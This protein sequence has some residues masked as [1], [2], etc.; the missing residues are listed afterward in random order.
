[1]SF[2]KFTKKLNCYALNVHTA[3]VALNYLTPPLLPNAKLLMYTLHFYAT[4]YSVTEAYRT[5]DSLVFSSLQNR[6]FSCLQLFTE[7]GL[8]EL[9]YL[10]NES[11]LKRKRQSSFLQIFIKNKIKRKTHCSS[12]VTTRRHYATIPAK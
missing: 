2:L 1:M 5:E 3:L 11:P 10:T 7:H 12:S 4:L 9:S 8:H 6:R